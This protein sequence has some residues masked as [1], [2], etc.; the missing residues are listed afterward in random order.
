MINQLLI[1]NLLPGVIALFCAKIAYCMEHMNGFI[2]S[3]IVAICRTKCL[4]VCEA[5]IIVL[6][7]LLTITP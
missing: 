1:L 4:F 7:P 3:K 6:Q 2:G 5:V